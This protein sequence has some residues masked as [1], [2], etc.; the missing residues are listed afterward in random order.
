MK[1]QLTQILDLPG[2]I[3][4][5]QKH[6]E[7]ALVLEVESQS[8]TARCPT[9]QKPSHRLHQNHWHLIKDLP[10]GKPEIF[11]RINRRQFKCNYCQKPFSEDLNF[12]GKRKKYTDRYA[13]W[14][15]EQVVN[16]NLLNVA[17]RNNLT[18]SEVESMINQISQKI[19]PINLKSLKRLGIDEISLVKGQGKFIVVLVDL[20][21]GKLIGLIQ[22]RKATAI[23]E[24]L[25]SWGPEILE[26]IEEVSM[27]LYKLYKSVFNKLCPEAVITADRFQ[28]TKLLHQE[29]NQGRIDQKK[30]A[31]ELEIEPRAQLFSS[32]KGGKYILLRNEKDLKEKQKEKLE[33]IKES[34]PKLAIMHA[35]KEEFTELFE[36]SKDVG[37]G[38]IKLGEWPIKA[39]KFFPKTV[40]TIKN[41]FGEIVGYFEQKTTQGIVEGINNRLKVIKRCAFGFTNFANFEKRALLFWYLVD[42]LA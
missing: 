23:E 3:V 32:L 11:L 13:Q 41:W 1:K 15:T 22:E 42:S 10:W 34:S 20:D 37:E 7:K 9:C 31:L 38:M 30:T 8:Q 28:V 29:L 18:E 14:I 35:L 39:E 36:S 6:L 25:K 5:S 27:D 21:P 19:L 24:L 26:Q 2:V 17:E 4:K 33:H 16:S 40:R 12:V